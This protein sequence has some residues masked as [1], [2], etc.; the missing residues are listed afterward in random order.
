MY[1]T[2]SVSL[3]IQQGMEEGGG[4]RDQSGG[5][6]S[7]TQERTG[8]AMQLLSPTPARPKRVGADGIKRGCHFPFL[9]ASLLG[10][11]NDACLLAFH[12][13]SVTPE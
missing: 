13:L 10:A 9:P 7:P 11:T 8:S 5:L 1:S 3:E 6:H 12:F 2:G 4:Q